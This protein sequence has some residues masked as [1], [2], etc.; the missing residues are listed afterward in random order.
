[1]LGSL[2]AWQPHLSISGC[3]AAFDMTDASSYTVTGGTTVTSITNKVSGTAWTEGTNPPAYEATGFN[4]SPCM[5]GDASN[6]QIISTEAAVVAAVT[7]TDPAYS[8][9]FV[10]D[11]VS[12]TTA[13]WLGFGAAGTAT[14]STHMFYQLAGTGIVQPR[15]FRVSDAGANAHPTTFNI[16]EPYSPM[17]VAWRAASGVASYYRNGTRLV[18]DTSCSTGATTPTRAALLCRPDS[19]PDFYAPS[20]LAVALL[21]SGD[22]GHGDAIRVSSRYMSRHGIS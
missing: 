13:A 20:R 15:I 6:D 2:M 3:V 10:V 21:F 4:G 1:M 17:V 18:T 16:S 19:S 7:G 22:I 9:L 12:T 14:N 8:A 11:P 5:K